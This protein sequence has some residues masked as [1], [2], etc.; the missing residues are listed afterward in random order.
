MLRLIPRAPQ[1]LTVGTLKKKLEADGFEVSECTI[2]RD[3]Q[4][5]SVL[6]PLSCDDR[7]R[8]YG[9]CWPREGRVLDIPGMDPQTALTFKLAETFLQSLMPR[10]TLAAMAPYME[11]AGNVLGALGEPGFARWP[12]KVRVIPRGQRLLSPDFKPEVLEVVY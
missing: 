1:K 10:S 7:N 5:L 4:S 2:Q 11:A 6:F 9:W 3:L 8:P 12:D